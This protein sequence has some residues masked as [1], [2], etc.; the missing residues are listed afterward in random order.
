MLDRLIQELSEV[1]VAEAR[2]RQEG[3][4]LHVI[5]GPKKAP[6]GK[7]SAPK[8]AAKSAVPAAPAPPQ[9]SSGG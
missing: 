5:F 9:E 6:G 4:F 1:G 7:G 3:R 8:A 2:A